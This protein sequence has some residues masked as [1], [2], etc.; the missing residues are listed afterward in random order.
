MLTASP[1][2]ANIPPEGSHSGLVHP[3]AKRES[4]VTGIMGSNPIPSAIQATSDMPTQQP[5]FKTIDEYIKTFPDEVQRILGRVRQTIRKAAPDAEE[6]ISYQL[7]TFKLR[8]RNL[9][10]F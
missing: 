1:C 5:Q 2:R 4:W 7:P 3:P 9:V 6:A 10:H 8:G